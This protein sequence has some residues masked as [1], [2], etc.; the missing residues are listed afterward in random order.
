MCYS[1]ILKT[2]LHVIE[3]DKNREMVYWLLMCTVKASITVTISISMSWSQI[4][5][6]YYTLSWTELYREYLEMVRLQF[7]YPLLMHL[8]LQ[9]HPHSKH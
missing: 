8:H 9:K 3:T 1:Q 7:L 2:M 5:K 6:N 4:L